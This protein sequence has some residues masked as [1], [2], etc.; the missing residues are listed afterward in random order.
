M[1]EPVEASE[2]Q[3]SDEIRANT[4]VD[5]N[6]SDES[7]DPDGISAKHG[8]AQSLDSARDTVHNKFNYLNSMTLSTEQ[9][10]AVDTAVNLLTK[11]QKE[12]LHR[13]QEKVASQDEPETSRGKGKTID[14]REWGNAGI[15]SEE[16]NIEAQEA[17]FDAY[18]RGRKDVDEKAKKSKDRN[19]KPSDGNKENFQIPPVPR[20]KSI[21]SVQN[22]EFQRAGS[23][24]ATQIVPDSSIGVALGNVAKLQ[25]DSGGPGDPSDSSSEYESSSYSRS[26]RSYSRSRSRS[27]RGRRHKSKRSKHRSRRKSRQSSRKSKSS[28]KPM[29]PKDYDGAAD[30][31]AYHRF[32]MEGE[33]YLRDGKVSRERQI[34]IL[35]HH[36]DGKAYD[37]YMQKVAPDDP[38][39]WNLHKFFTE[40][41]NY[42]FPVDYRQRMRLKL[43]DYYQKNN[44][45]VSEY[46]FELQ[47]MFS[48]VGAM[49]PEMKVIKLW[50]SMKARIQRAMWRDGLH[51]DSSTWDEVVAKAEMIEI[52]DNVIDPRDR[53]RSQMQSTYRNKNG[54]TN[55]QS[56]TDSASH[57]VMYVN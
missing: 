43:E 29:P 13:R 49:S 37:F 4:D 19:K 23:R 7:E 41:F 10:K 24:P 42:C 38:S 54:N 55:K 46:V 8:R 36:L 25:K 3:A 45:T 28:I 56:A 5:A 31:R 40:L 18:E 39:D 47:E 16:L 57:S 15:A 14:P 48:M 51:P 12:Q 34:R 26:T 27:R 20:H 11:E 44:Q 1:P 9:E 2:I 32:V 50:Y 6:T 21:T 17:M 30:S 22:F 52:A 33:A 53:N 35:A